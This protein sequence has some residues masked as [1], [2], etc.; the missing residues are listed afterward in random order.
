[1]TEKENFGETEIRDRP[2]EA[3]IQ[4]CGRLSEEVAREQLSTWSMLNTVKQQFSE[5]PEREV[6]DAALLAIEERR[7]EQAWK[8]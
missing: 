3:L 8:P 7:K 4:F 1:M 5:L 6:I 2:R